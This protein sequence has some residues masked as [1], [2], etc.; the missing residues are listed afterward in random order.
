MGGGITVESTEGKGS[1]FQLL[2]PFKV[3]H[4]VSPSTSA[5]QFAMPEKTDNPLRILQAEDNHINAKFVHTLLTK[6][7][8]IPTTVE[9]GKQVID[10][11]AKES[12][13]LVLMDIQMP[14]M[15]G[16]EALLEMRNNSETSNIPVIALTAFALKGEQERFMTDG[17]DGYV[18]KPVEIQNLIDEIARVMK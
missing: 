7:G 14:V 12:F 9:D 17:F 8:H 15:N 5:L 2:V 18:S 16:E 4:Y 10:I 1:V 11:L 6:L 3:L 13:D